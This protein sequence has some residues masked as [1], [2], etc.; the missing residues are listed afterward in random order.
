MEPPAASG[1]GTMLTGEETREREL[2]MYG[3]TFACGDQLRAMSLLQ[4]FA[5]PYRFVDISR[6]RAAAERLMGWVGYMSVPTLVVTPSGE[7]YPEL[8]PT[9]LDRTRRIRGQNRGTL[10][11]EPDDAQLILFLDQHQLL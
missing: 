7:E 11:T 3:R 4:R 2:V 1:N 10:I 8:P 6:D 9:P 5:V